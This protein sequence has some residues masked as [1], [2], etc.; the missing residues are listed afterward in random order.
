[1]PTPPLA[2]RRTVKLAEGPLPFMRRITTPW[3]AWT[4]SRSPSRMRKFTFTV[5]PGPKSGILGLLSGLSIW[6]AS[7]CYGLSRGVRLELR[8]FQNT[9]RTEKSLKSAFYDNTLANILVRRR[10]C[11]S[12][13]IA[14]RAGM[15]TAVVNLRQVR[16]FAKA[17]GKL[18][19]TDTLDA[20]VLAQFGEAAKPQP[21]LGQMRQ[22]FAL[23]LSAG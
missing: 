9:V 2:T 14:S 23:Q 21:R 10:G 7:I 16:D 19:K 3:K 12:R 17:L 4:R 18:T 20:P 11:N 6:G 1:M 13:T 22:R 5:S 15:G 8:E